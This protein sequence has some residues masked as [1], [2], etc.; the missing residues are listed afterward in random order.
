MHRVKSSTVSEVRDYFAGE[1]RTVLSKRKVSADQSFDYLVDLLVRYMRSD[2]FFEQTPD[3]KLQDNVLANLY[4]KYL[5]GD[6]ET[7]HFALKRLGDVCLLITGIFPESLR[8]KIVGADYY[9]GMGGAAYST[10]SELQFS[11]I[12]RTLFSELASKFRDYSNILSELSEAH[13]L[14][15]N[16]DLLQLYERWLT[17]GDDRLKARLA[18]KGIIAADAKIFKV[19]Q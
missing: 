2:N 4:A 5:E 9:F 12:A 14:Q 16:T 3:G 13:G 1:L 7:R 17:T 19:S 15:R 10:L 11:Q 6:G 8:R 18:E